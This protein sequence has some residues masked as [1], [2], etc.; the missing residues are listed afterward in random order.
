MPTALR[1]TSD[2]ATGTVLGRWASALA[3]A[4]AAL[5]VAGAALSVGAAVPGDDDDDTPGRALAVTGVGAGVG[6]ALPRG[7]PQA[8]TEAVAASAT[9]R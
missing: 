6:R 7:P 9:D 2:F 5:P 3:R 1:V 8:D 4:P